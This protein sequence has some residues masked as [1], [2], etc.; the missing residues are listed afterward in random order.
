MLD[1][2]TVRELALALPETEEQDHRGHPSF[3]IRGK[4]FAT[5]RPADGAAV[6]CEVAPKRL[7]AAV[8]QRR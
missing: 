6:D 3:H 4:I 5:L 7:C 1:S 2:Q 8:E